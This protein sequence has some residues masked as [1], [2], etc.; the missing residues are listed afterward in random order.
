M[1][2]KIF[3]FQDQGL[4]MLHKEL[5][6]GPSSITPEVAAISFTDAE[7]LVY[8]DVIS[9]M[10]AASSMNTMTD[11][12]SITEDIIMFSKESSQ[13]PSGKFQENLGKLSKVYLKDFGKISSKFRE[14]LGQILSKS[15]G[16]LRQ[17]LGKSWA[18]LEQISGRSRANLGRSR[19]HIGQ[20]T[21]KSL[22]NLRQIL[23][24]S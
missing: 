8:P 16:N 24:K 10:A 15:R 22:A 5:S 23:G 7:T 19:A 3:T 20:L 6:P 11:E 13:G 14:N 18:N 1:S 9:K 12:S 4:H 17:I 21:G 2:C